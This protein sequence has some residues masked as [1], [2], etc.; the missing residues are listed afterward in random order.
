MP[1]AIRQRSPEELAAGYTRAHRLLEVSAIV[2]F[3]ALLANVITIL[4]AAHVIS[5]GFRIREDGRTAGAIGESNQYAAF[6]IL[7]LPATIAA[8]AATPGEVYN[9]GGGEMA[10]VWDILHRLEA[11]IGVKAQA[12]QLA[13]RPGDQRHTF[14]DT[15]K[16]RRHL[17]WEPRVGLDEGLARQVE[18]QKQNSE[19]FP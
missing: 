10:S 12:R 3:G 14:A 18:W 17:G 7:F 1:S 16:L 19:F 11:I 9:V 6:I 5:L 4:D 13:A 8:A 15:T 2:L